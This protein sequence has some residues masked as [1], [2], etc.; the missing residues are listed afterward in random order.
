M[1]FSDKKNQKILAV[2]ENTLVIGCDIGKFINVARAIDFRGIEYGNPLSFPN[3]TREGFQC[4]LI[5]AKNVA[6]LAK[7]TKVFF[8][9]EP[10]GH[11]WWSIAQFIKQ[12]TNWKFAIVNSYHVY[13]GK[14]KED[15]SPTKNDCKDAIVIAKAIKDGSYYY[16]VIPNESY[17]ELRSAMIQREDLVKNLSRLKCKL[18]TWLDTYFP[19]FLTVFKSWEGKSAMLALRNFPLPQ[20]LVAAGSVELADIWKKNMKCGFKLYKS[21]D[22]WLC[23]SKSV[24]I[25]YGIKLARKQIEFLL[26]Q[27]DF[28][29]EQLDSLMSYVDELLNNMED[30]KAILTMKGVG[31]VTAAAFLAEVGDLRNYQ[32]P[33]QIL[34]LAGLNLTEFSSGTHKSQTKIS[35]RG[36][37]R[38]RSILYRCAIMAICKNPE[39]K[40]LHKYFTTRKENPLKKKQSVIAICSKLIRI[41][42][43]LGKNRIAYDKEKAL[44]IFHV[45]KLKNAI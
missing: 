27:Y 15:N 5:W 24:G 20:D 17:A 10:T 37:A 16:P 18:Q 3:N 32:H 25:T 41:F 43:H 35:K 38:L 2:D 28:I 30:A 44:G 4:L 7:K 13:L 12:E 23:A 14:E 31:T 36:R 9:C 42:M 11:Y 45:N 39:I 29:K 40:A 21:Y 1:K 8:G 33:K 34:R 6:A 22:L 19:E 26:A